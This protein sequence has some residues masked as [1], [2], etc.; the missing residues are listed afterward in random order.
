MKKKSISVVLLAYNEEKNL[1]LILPNVNRILSKMEIDY[2]ILI[3]DSEKS[4]DHSKEVA[5]KNHARYMIQEEPYY[6]GAFRTGIKY[7]TKSRMMV[8]D[9]DGSHNPKD[10]PRIYEK[11]EK[12]YDMVIGSR[13]VKGGKSND[14]KLSLVMSKVLNLIMR[15]I[16]GVKA[17]DISTSYRLYDME[18][19][20]AV[21]LVRNH[22]D[23]LQ[24]VILKMKINKRKKHQRFSIGE[25]P[26]I[27]QKRRYGESK[28][29]L[30]KFIKGY[31]YTAAMLFGINIRSIYK[32]R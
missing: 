10:I 21:T 3:I 22:Y 13:Y 2:E 4:T 9:A 8:L 1:K 25:V 5:E 20:K 16:I 11:F 14:S 26:I 17:K 28:R 30:W 27:F 6:G 7:A 24:E 19:L 29:Q 12:G 15:K 31:I 23:V 18:Q 32:D